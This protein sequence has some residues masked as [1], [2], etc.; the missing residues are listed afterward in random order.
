MVKTCEI[1]TKD[2]VW[3]L[4]DEWHL[5][6]PYAIAEYRR[7]DDTYFHP[8][9]DGKDT[10]HSY[11]SLEGALAGVISIQHDGINTRAD[12]YFMRAIGLKE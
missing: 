6:G 7:G 9:L 11:D 2:F 10:N 8:Y 12:I 3:G 1:P 5:V 4:V